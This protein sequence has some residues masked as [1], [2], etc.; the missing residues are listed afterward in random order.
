MATKKRTTPKEPPTYE[1]EVLAV[2]AFEFSESEH[3]ES[4]RKIKRRLRD[5]HLG[6]YEQARIDALRT[7][8]DDVQRELQ[9]T[10]QSKFY[11]GS[12]GHYGDMQDWHFDELKRHFAQRHSPLS[13]ATI[14][15]FLPHAIY[16][17]YLR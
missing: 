7:F 3:A 6:A 16:L 10:T 4:D 11:A 12:H 8:K 1:A 14:A 2:L 5:K 15:G 17:Y 9:S 13:E